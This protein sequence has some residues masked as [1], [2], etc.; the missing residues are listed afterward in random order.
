MVM[1]KDPP[2][3]KR[4]VQQTLVRH[5]NALNKLAAKG[6]RFWD[7]GNAFLQQA[8]IAGADVGVL[9]ESR[10]C[11]SKAM[12]EC[13]PSGK[14][15]KAPHTEGRTGDADKGGDG[16]TFRYP[17]YVQDIMG[18]IFSLGFGPFRW[19]CTSQSSEDLHCTDAI[20]ARELRQMLAG[21][22]SPLLASIQ[23]SEGVEV[24]D[25][26]PPPSDV[27][28]QLRDNLLWIERAEENQLVVG[29]Q[30]RTSYLHRWSSCTPLRFRLS[31]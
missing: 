21:R 7:Y 12:R 1:V 15:E 4:L 28:Q 30:V 31:L 16:K 24:T 25:G 18:D 10:E 22:S 14:G 27:A 2:R 13:E 29:S 26:V 3:F 11:T 9:D 6:L 17:S 8:F 19:V 20:A 23:E 5:V